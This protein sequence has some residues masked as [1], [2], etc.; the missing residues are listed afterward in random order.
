LS[1]VVPQDIADQI[2]AAIAKAGDDSRLAPIKLLLPETIS[3]GQ[4]RCVI[5]AFKLEQGRGLDEK[6]EPKSN[7]SEIRHPQSEIEAFLSRSR[8]RPLKGPWHS[9]WALG[10]HSRF[11]G[12]DWS[13]SGV[14]E[15]AYRLKYRNDR[16][17]LLPLVEQMLAL[18][19]EYH[20]LAEVDVIAPVPP[21]TQRSL[22]PVRLVADS[23]GQRLKRPV[24][25][26]LVRT[27]RTAPQKE[28]RSLAQKHANVAGAFVVQGNVRGMKVLLL[29][30]LYDSG[31][32]LEEAARVLERAGASRI[33]V[34]T[35]TRTI[36]SDA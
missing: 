2:R 8:P 34:L 15:L 22:D 29:D 36:H 35:L 26:I 33:C 31:A 7:E 1:A 12:A 28:M 5:E 6:L 27:R 30:D 20:E 24:Q 16:S 10:F 19:Q 32:T 13:R 3:Y 25:S 21:S 18:I 4:I 17:A 23:L 14:G 11:A 9:G